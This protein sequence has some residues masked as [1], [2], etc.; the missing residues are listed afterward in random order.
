MASVAMSRDSNAQDNEASALLPSHSLAFSPKP[1]PS[2]CAARRLGKYVA[3]ALGFITFI[4]VGIRLRNSADHDRTPKTVPWLAPWTPCLANGLLCSSL[5]VPLVYDEVLLKGEQPS[6][7]IELALI[8]R[9]GNGPGADK[10][11]IFLNPGGPGASG[12]ELVQN[13]GARLSTILEGAHDLVSFDPRGV[14]ASSVIKCWETPAQQAHAVASY[15]LLLSPFPDDPQM[16]ALRFA[17]D[18]VIAARCDR[19]SGSALVSTLSTATV[20]RDMDLLRQAMDLEDVR[21][22]GFSY[23]TFLGT[24]Y[25]NMFPERVGRFVLDGATDPTAWIGDRFDDSLMDTDQTFDA[26]GDLC[27]AAGPS[28]CALAGHGPVSVSNQI[29]AYIASLAKFPIAVTAN[30]TNPGILSSTMVNGAVF[31]SLYKPRDFA[32]LARVL[33]PAMHEGNPLP[34]YE[35]VAEPPF[36]EKDIEVDSENFSNAA[37]R[38]GDAHSRPTEK[39]VLEGVARTRKMS[40]LAGSTWSWSMSSCITWPEVREK[41]LGPWNATTKNKIL[42]ISNSLD[43]NTPH[44]HGVR[45]NAALGP[46]SSRLLTQHALG[47]CSTAQA[48][49]CTEKAVRAYFAEGGRGAEDIETDFCVADE[50]LFPEQS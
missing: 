19:Y 22:W 11:P 39:D 50:N 13:L 49:K 28:R 15:S 43:P 26:V 37:F 1:R 21:Y 24:V 23:G 42:I 32:G 30:T 48:S 41:Y 33:A 20:A 7:T 5:T 36:D 17:A 40:P 10:S 46:E 31:Q 45:L 44:E 38:C 35:H 29:R 27:E 18:R 47:H 12:I 8:K 4:F 2:N 9:P 25:A 6:T 3:T 34:L 16:A 14:G